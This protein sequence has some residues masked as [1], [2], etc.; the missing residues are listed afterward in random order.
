M[1]PPVRRTGAGGG[2]GLKMIDR[3]VIKLSAKPM[4]ACLGVTLVVLLLERA[5][6][7]FDLL[8]Q[9]SARFGYVFELTANLIP[10]YL[11]L[12]MPASFF[13]AIF[14]VSIIIIF[15]FS[16]NGM[17]WLGSSLQITIFINNKVVFRIT[18]R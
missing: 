12:A 4:A 17:F 6:R 8:A 18:N 1:K 10:H 3:Y 5:L 11:G 2:L 15:S 14:I 13:I 16:F 7:I 9:S